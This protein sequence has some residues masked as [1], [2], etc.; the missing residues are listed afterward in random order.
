M[1]TNWNLSLPF[2]VA[3][4]G[5]MGGLQNKQAPF[6]VPSLGFT[7]A[8]EAIWLELGKPQTWLLPF[9]KKVSQQISNNMHELQQC[10]VLY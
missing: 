8:E 4:L 7:D 10:L 2:V 5:Q 9:T 6:T 1:R 3:N